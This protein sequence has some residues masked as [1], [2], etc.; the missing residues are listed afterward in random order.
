MTSHTL[1]RASAFDELATAYRY[2]RRILKAQIRLRSQVRG[3]IKTARGMAIDSELPLPT[4]MRK[5][6]SEAERVLVG[7]LLE[8]EALLRGHLLRAKKDMEAQA[9]ELPIWDAW[10]KEVTGLGPCNLACILGE[11]GDLSN[12]SGPAKLWKRFGL[13][14]GQRKHRDVEKAL[15]AGYSPSRR[16]V[17]HVTGSL[18]LLTKQGTYH[19]VYLERKRFELVKAAD[20]GLKVA[21][22]GKI[23][24]G[25]TA[26]Y[27]SE[28]HIHMRALRYMEKRLLRDLWRAWRDL[29]SVDTLRISVSLRPAPPGPSLYP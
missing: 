15:E 23:P 2:R 6:L 13:A 24:K 17:M 11:S 7:P 4:D 26:E 14:P 8:A 16:A 10:A 22:A 27:R 19:E 9:R 21:P 25:K 3:T 12:Y 28:G 20:E 29:T 18:G 5:K 1:P